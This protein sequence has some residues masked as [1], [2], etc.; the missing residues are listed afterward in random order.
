MNQEDLL[1]R[2]VD[3]LGLV[4]CHAVV[5]TG[6]GLRAH[7]LSRVPDDVHVVDSVPHG[8]VIP[9]VDLVVTHGGHGTVVR[10]LAGGVPVVIVPISRDQ[11]DNAARAVHHGAGVSVS[12]RSSPEKFA[13]AIRSALADASIRAGARQLAD[14]MAPDLGAPN[15]IAALEALAARSAGPADPA[16]S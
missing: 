11:P 2:L 6:P 4:D 1:Q 3:A 12:K 7:R 9:H 14:R 8:A 5:T 10:S 15:A 13:T 16:R